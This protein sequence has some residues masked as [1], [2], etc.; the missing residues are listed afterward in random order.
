MVNRCYSY[1]LLG[2]LYFR[3]L[4]KSSPWWARFETIGL[5]FG[6]MLLVILLFGNF[7]VSRWLSEMALAMI[8]CPFMLKLAIHYKTSYWDQLA[9]YISY[10]VFL[11]HIPVLRFL[12][13]KGDSINEFYIAFAIAVL[14]S[15]VIHYL[16]EKPFL[17]IRR[18]M[19]SQNL[20]FFKI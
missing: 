15:L 5:T 18:N 7:A 12:H 2:F 3:H 17:S 8:V 11:V 16:I 10:G 9:G 13:L 6:L 20:K 19:A 4:K 1:F 14:I